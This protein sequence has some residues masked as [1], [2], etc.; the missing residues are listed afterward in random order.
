VAPGPPFNELTGQLATAIE[1][2]PTRFDFTSP[3]LAAFVEAQAR[4]RTLIQGVVIRSR[5]IFNFHTPV[6]L[7]PQLQPRITVRF[8]RIP[9][10]VAP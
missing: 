3:R 4:G 9:T 7:S 6:S 5:D 8:Q 2:G 1:A 10:A